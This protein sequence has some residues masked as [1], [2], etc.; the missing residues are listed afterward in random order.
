MA[1]LVVKGKVLVGNSGGEFG[2][3]GWLTALNA[4]DGHARLARLQHRPRRRRPDRRA[5]PAVLRSGPRQGSR[6]Q[7]LAA[8]SL[9]DRRRHGVGLDLLRPGAGPHLLRHRQP[10]PVEPRAAARRQQVD[11]GHLRAR[12][13]RRRRRSGPT[14]G[15]RTTCTTTTASTRTC[16]SICRSNGQHAQGAGAPRAQRLP[17]RARPADRRGAVGRS[18]RPHHH[19]EGRRPARPAA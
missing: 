14:S 13:R 10:R 15:A 5:L 8:G 18:L 9:E 7:H 6:R 16:C 19:V 11:R 12:S 4:A 1:P 2:V 3:R 17:V